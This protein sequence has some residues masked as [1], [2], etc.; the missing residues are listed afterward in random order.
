MFDLY[1]F[2]PGLS[3]LLACHS[4]KHCY[5]VT[6]NSFPDYFRFCFRNCPAGF[7]FFFWSFRSVRRSLMSS[8]WKNKKLVHFINTVENAECNHGWC[9]QLLIVIKFYRSPY[10]RFLNK[11]NWV[12]VIETFHYYIF[13][14]IFLNVESFGMVASQTVKISI[15]KFIRVDGQ[16]CCTQGGGG[17]AQGPP[18]PPRIFSKKLLNKYQITSK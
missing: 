3:I 6:L 17:G 12:K 11:N 13:L 8:N 15:P 1:V 18:P 4:P 10:I 9:Y 14:E 5:R 16:H 7:F 2:C